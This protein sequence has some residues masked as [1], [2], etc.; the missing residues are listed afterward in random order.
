M[1]L[2]WLVVLPPREAFTLGMAMQQEQLSPAVL[3][4]MFVHWQADTLKLAETDPFLG[5][6]APVQLHFQL[7]VLE[8]A[9]V[10]LMHKQV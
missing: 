6:E 9:F 1:L 10:T 5:V 3:S 4:V 8:V 7:H 2:E